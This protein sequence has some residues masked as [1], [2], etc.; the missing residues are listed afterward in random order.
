MDSR[1][2][3]ILKRAL[4]GLVALLAFVYGSKYHKR[5]SRKD[6][7]VAEMRT[8]VSEAS[9]YRAVSEKDARTT[10]LRGIALLHE[11]KRLGME[12]A[13][14]FNG[15]FENKDAKTAD[16]GEFEDYPTR[17]KLARESLTRAY[18]HAGQLGLLAGPEEVAALAQGELPQTA[19]RSAI[20]CVIDPAIAPGL[21]KVVPN[22][23]LRPFDNKN[24]APSET[25]IAAA[26][27]LATDLASSQII[28]RETEA[29]INQHFRP[30]EPAK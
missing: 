27:K 7:I 9:F 17:E 15:V 16:E 12:P 22:F 4:Y 18:Q 13:A 28:D 30:K 26:R 25:D 29:K 1:A 21:E 20:I 24:A 2:S 3:S 19:T 11:A 10:F 8:L 23:E 6:A 14:V 5:E